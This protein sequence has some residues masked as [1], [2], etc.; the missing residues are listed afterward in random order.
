MVRES[1][2]VAL[3]SG[4]YDGTVVNVSELLD[5]IR[6]KWGDLDDDRGAYCNGEWLSVRDVVMMIVNNA[7]P[8]GF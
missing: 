1:Y 3:D 7:Y 8:E 5:L 6:G 4:E 2:N